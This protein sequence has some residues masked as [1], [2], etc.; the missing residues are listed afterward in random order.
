M[1]EAAAKTD[2]VEC[3]A[4]EIFPHTPRLALTATADART[5]LDE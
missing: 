5:R 1:V 3:V 2:V 4:A